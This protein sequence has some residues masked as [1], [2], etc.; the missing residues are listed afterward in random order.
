VI[1]KITR[2]SGFRGTLAYTLARD[3]EPEIVGGNMAGRNA[4][5]LAQEF[6]AVRQLRPDVEKPVMHVSLSFDPGRPDHPGDRVLSS[7]D[8]A[9][10]SAD[11]LKRM[12]YDLDRLQWVAVRHRDKEHQHVHLVVSR[13]RLDGSL[14]HQPWE[15]LRNQS[16]CRQIERD[17]RYNLRT[18]VQTR[19]PGVRAPT[20]GEDRMLRDRGL[21]SEKEKLKRWIQEAARGRPSM[22]EF[23]HRLESRGVQ[24]RPNLARTGH[25]SGI[26]YRLGRVAVKGSTLGRN[27]SWEGLQRAHGVRYER[28]RDRLT[29]ERAARVSLGQGRHR[30]PTS[31]GIQMVLR[32]G[33][34]QLLRNQLPVVSRAHGVAQA[35]RSLS[36]GFGTS[37]RGADLGAALKLMAALDPRVA[38]L[39]RI[40]RLAAPKLREPEHDPPIELEIP[41]SPRDEGPDRDR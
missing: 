37:G 2:G 7:E 39:E 25:V 15:Y 32:A 27:F 16:V 5:D 35:V 1:A 17:P 11:Y 28:G 13:V 24:V 41:F 10:I 29:I 18:I 30:S 23:I 3:H 12:G 31:P 9:R 38:S 6:G 22:S 33:V 20:R 34:R 4:R 26:S 8:M 36:R 40:L 19:E 21:L 14:V